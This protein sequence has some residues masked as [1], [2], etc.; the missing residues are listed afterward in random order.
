MVLGHCFNDC[1]YLAEQR[2]ILTSGWPG[3]SPFSVYWSQFFFKFYPCT[4]PVRIQI[5]PKALPGDKNLALKRPQILL[6]LTLN[7]KK[8]GL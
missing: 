1:G 7:R 3:A 2:G 6:K 5:L 8:R 4:G